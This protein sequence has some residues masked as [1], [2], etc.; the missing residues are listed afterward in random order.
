MYI[1]MYVYYIMYPPPRNKI[2]FH[3]LG[4]VH[5]VGPSIHA[6]MFKNNC[7]PQMIQLKTCMII[8]VVAE[9]NITQYTHL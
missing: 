5:T 8:L 4:K 9:H 7:I 1:T 2:K 3:S 6:N